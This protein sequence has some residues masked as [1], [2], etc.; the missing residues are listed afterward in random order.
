MLIQAHALTALY[1]FYPTDES[2]KPEESGGNEGN[3]DEDETSGNAAEA[4]G[5]E[6]DEEQGRGNKES[7]PRVSATDGSEPRAPMSC[8]VVCC[9]MFIFSI[10]IVG[11]TLATSFY[12]T[13]WAINKNEMQT[14]PVAPT[15]PTLSPASTSPTPTNDTDGGPTSAPLREP[16]TVVNCPEGN[17]PIELVIIFDSAPGDVG[18]FL[19]DKSRSFL[20]NFGTGSFLS[21]T[22]LLR[23]NYFIVCLSPQLE[24]QVEIT[25]AAGDGLASTF[26]GQAVFGGFRLSYQNQLVTNYS[27]DCSL[28]GFAECG[29]FCS[30]SYTLLQNATSGQ[31]TTSCNSTS[32][33]ETPDA[34]VPPVN[35]S[36]L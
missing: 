9:L 1:H 7:R 35:A 29:D 4:F 27:G 11:A 13:T 19:R 10:L 2:S 28:D 32:G 30:C 14:T 15:S 36:A 21:F 34:V 12:G 26:V 22:Q 5:D 25:D 18:I 24:Y 6:Y 31:C 8:A 17:V 23:E 20:W 16:D 3:E 33:E